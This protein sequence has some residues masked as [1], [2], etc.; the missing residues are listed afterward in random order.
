M[1][2]V[3]RPNVGKST[4]FNR[5]AGRKLAIV[6]DR[7]GVTRDRKYA[8]GSLSD[9]SFTLIDTAGF[10]DVTDGS[11]E[12]R[13][14]QQTEVAIR[15]AD[16][17][18]FVID[19]REGV[20]MLDK[21]F[22]EVLRRAS[23]SVVLVAN[24]AEGKPDNAMIADAFGLGLGAP[25]LV[26]A[27][28]GEGMGDLYEALR[29]LS[30]DLA[31]IEDDTLGDELPADLGLSDEEIE[32]LED[33][34]ET[35][36]EA[37]DEV[38]ET[39]AKEGRA[40]PMRLA[41]V[42][43][44]NAG[45]SSLVNALLQ[46]DRLLTG[47]EAGITRDAIEVP[48]EWQGRELRLI[49]TAGLRKRSK[50]QDSLERQSTGDTIRALKFADIVALVMDVREAFE[51]QD[52]QLADLILREGRGLVFVITKLDL[53]DDPGKVMREMREKADD[54][55]SQAKGAPIVGL[56]ALTGRNVNRL[57]PAALKLYDDWNAKVKTNDVN[58]WLQY[59]VQKQAPPSTDGH[60]PKL[61]YI[62]QLKGR[63]PTF[64]IMCTRAEH[65]PDTYR[66][67]LING[68]REAFDMQGVP[69]RLLLRQSS[70][71]FRKGGGRR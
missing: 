56:S 51:R 36:I 64:V 27:E 39:K 46:D 55:L 71:P 5:L 8:P 13:M 35:A 58:R 48:W 68:L 47:P 19:A 32:A 3:G 14:R 54:S 42:G 57:L 22:A 25:V 34:D 45:K 50:V 7:P 10:D 11:L 24:K 2:L 49:D 41:I 40:R 66:R 60:R 67:Y 33:L 15:E 61:R 16:I 37:R 63:P 23:K 6:H 52:L 30:D 69:I 38:L 26:S 70:N 62:A 20:T 43:R 18:L 59:A 65:I 17:C 28:H 21:R 44:P 12:S 53:V 29:P 4:L 9:L 1:A 31:P